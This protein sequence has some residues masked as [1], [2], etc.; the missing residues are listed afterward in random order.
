[1]QLDGVSAAALLALVAFAIDRVVSALLFFLIY[2]RV[3]SDPQRGKGEARIAAEKTYKL[4]YF[5]VALILVF[6]VLKMYTS[7]RI[8][9]AMG[10]TTEAPLLDE[11]LTGVVLLGGSDRLGEWLSREAP[12]IAEEES[13]PPVKVTGTLTLD[14]RRSTG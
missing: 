13:P 6:V 4:V 14:D 5:V 2:V 12:A 1:M 3:L 10:S 9:A 11:F 8:L 7:I